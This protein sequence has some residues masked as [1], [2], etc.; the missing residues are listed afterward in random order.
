MEV[1]LD[2]LVVRITRRGESLVDD[3]TFGAR[4]G[5]GSDRFIQLSEGVIPEEIR[6]RR[7]RACG[8]GRRAGAV[9]GGGDRRRAARRR[10]IVR[11]ARSIPGP[12]RVLAE[13]RAADAYRLEAG[14]SRVRASGSPASARATAWL[15]PDRAQGRRLAPTAATPARTARPTAG[16]GRHPPGRLLADALAALQRRRARLDRDRRRRAGA[17]PA[18]SGIAVSQR[19]RRRA[20]A[21][22][23]DLRPHA[24]RAPAPLPAADRDAAGPGGVGLRALEEPRRLRAPAGRR[25]G[26]PGLR[27]AL[28]AARRDRDRLALGDAVQHLA[29]QPQPV[30]GPAAR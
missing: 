4:G 16:R 28:A 29:L 14:W 6:D 27:P 30:A 10:A 15:R 22:A 3:M 1:R 26:L 11:A 20:V 2:P 8:H 19:G 7:A 24:G 25:G 17:R 13:L 12:A 5:E 9:R 21:A 23:P 18:A